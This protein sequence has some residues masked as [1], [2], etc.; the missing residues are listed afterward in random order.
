MD[1]TYE[2]CIPGEVVEVVWWVLLSRR[3]PEWLHVDAEV[4][5]VVARPLLQGEDQLGGVL[6]HQ[7][8]HLLRVPTHH[9]LV[10][11]L[12]HLKTVMML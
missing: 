10:V 8:Q 1:V 11:D 7:P 5:V 6:L 3:D 4:V 2:C 9:S 12:H